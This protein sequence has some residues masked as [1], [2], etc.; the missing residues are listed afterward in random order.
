MMAMN[1]RFCVRV[2]ADGVIL[3]AGEDVFTLNHD[4]ATWLVLQLQLAV[5]RLRG[6]APPSEHVCVYCNQPGAGAPFC[7][8]KGPEHK[9]RFHSPC[10]KMWAADRRKERSETG[11]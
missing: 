2:S 6:N 11:Q 5:G 9:E 3:L 1:E 10:R 7:V 4:E 8:G